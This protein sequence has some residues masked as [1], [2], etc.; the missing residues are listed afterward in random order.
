MCFFSISFNESKAKRY[1]FLSL[2][3]VQRKLKSVNSLVFYLQKVTKKRIARLIHGHHFLHF[4]LVRLLHRLFRRLHPIESRVPLEWL[5][6][7]PE[8]PSLASE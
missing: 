5:C 1:P 8:Y 3:L 2:N 4:L 6:P 7:L